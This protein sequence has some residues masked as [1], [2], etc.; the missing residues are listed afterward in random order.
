MCDK[1][2]QR[3]L[4]TGAASGIGRSAVCALSASGRAVLAVA[5]RGDRLQEL[6]E[7]TGCECVACDVRDL[8]RIAPEIEEFKPDIVVN[9]AGVGHGLTGVRDIGPQDV[10]AS[11]ETNILAPIQ[12]TA[13]ALAGMKRR[14]CGHIVNIGSIA[15]LHTMVS[16]LYGA[17]KSAVHTFSQNLR[18]ELAGTRIRV[19]EICPGRVRSEFY[20]AAAGDASALEEM[21]TTSI[22]ALHPEDVAAAIMFAVDAPAHVNISTIEMLPTEQIVGGVRMA[23]VEWED[24]PA[25]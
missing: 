13:C 25:A 17:T 12:I 18:V 22:R 14:E 6:A 10:R 19:S 23:P 21:G 7:E 3:A 5:R 11:V 20:R 16:A 1:S 8:E 9:N 4:V 24:G 15:G 2:L